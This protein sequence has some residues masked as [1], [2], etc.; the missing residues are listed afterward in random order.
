MDLSAGFLALLVG[1]FTLG[2]LH[3]L[4]PGHGKT[5]MG[6]YLVASRG[7]IRHAFLLGLM[8]TIT[9]TAVVFLLAAG[10][11]YFSRWFHQEQVAYWLG[12]VSASLVIAVGGWMS[13]QA[14]GLMKRG[15]THH[16]HDD[17]KRIQTDAGAIELSV[18]EVGVPPRFRAHFKGKSGEPL[19]PSPMDA[20]TLETTRE[21]GARQT[22]EFAPKG[23]FLES[24]SDIPEPHQ[25]SVALRVTHEGHTHTYQTRYLEHDHGHTHET[26]EEVAAHGHSHAVAVPQG[27][28]PLGFGTLAMIGASGGLVPC[29][30]ALTAF[31][32]ALNLGQPNRGIGIVVALSLG[33]ASTLIAIG[34][35]FVK[36]R[37]WADKRYTSKGR[38][39]KLP[40]LSAGLIMLIG[41]GMLVAALLPHH[42][43]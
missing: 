17:L 40:R 34:I 39:A 24:T 43:H 25:F 4:E 13:F 23:D 19:Q 28:D 12:I 14:F 9:H 36:A 42:P 27:K 18:F 11:I 1:A 33:I 31:L 26:D 20:V 30:A 7:G 5:I 3:A 2:A 37:D 29:P 32:A 16:D 15:H 21:D 41:V 8:V 35:L 10:A 6:A 38:L 22:F